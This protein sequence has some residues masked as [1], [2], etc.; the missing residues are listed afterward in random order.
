MS[1]SYTQNNGRYSAHI[2][3]V[4][5]NQVGF[6]NTGLFLNYKCKAYTQLDIGL[7]IIQGVY[8]VVK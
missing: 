3:H 4:Y 6:Y 7:Y 8:K 1:C 5:I 2:I